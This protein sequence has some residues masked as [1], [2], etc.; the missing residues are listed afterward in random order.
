METL[1]R[2]RTETRPQV[3]ALLFA[4]ALRARAKG[5]PC[6]DVRN[7]RL[8]E[9]NLRGARIGGG[10]APWDLSGA[11]FTGADLREAEFSHTQLTQA[12][13]S[14][15]S[16]DRACFT[17]AHLAQA[18]FDAASLRGSIFRRCDLIDSRWTNAVA[19]RTQMQFCTPAMAWNDSE[20]LRAPTPEAE[21]AG[22]LAWLAGH[23]DLVSACAWSADGR[24]ASASYDGTLR[25]W[26]PNTGDCL[27]AAALWER[28]DGTS[29]HVVWS[30]V[31]NRVGSG[32]DD[33]WR[34][35]A[36]QVPDAQ[37]RLTRLPIETF[38]A[39]PLDPPS[40]RRV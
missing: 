35:L 25:L 16:L 6:P 37:A 4:Y 17:D 30:P 26:N 29:G 28:A 24:L 15:A 13:F 1:A 10:E 11:I 5:W 7:I 32:S 14:G 18:C 23:S 8:D 34:F 20:V 12:D 22:N 36:W 33:A 3:N 27:F 19:L 2:W 40:Y 31:E 39:L 21:S 38:G 9:A